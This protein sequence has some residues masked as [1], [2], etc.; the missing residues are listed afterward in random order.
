MK[1]FNI[2]YLFI[3]AL[4]MMV[5]SACE[6]DIDKP[7]EWPEWGNPSKPAVAAAE[8]IPSGSSADI[9]AGDAVQFSAKL[10]DQYNKLKQAEVEVTLGTN[11]VYTETFA[12]DGLEANVVS[13]LKIPFLKN[14]ENNTKLVAKLKIRN[15]T[16][17]GLTEY[18]L[19][20]ELQLSV[21]RPQFAKLYLVDDQGMVVEMGKEQASDYTYMTA[22]NISGLSSKIWI[23]EKVTAQ[24]KP[25]YTEFV[26]GVI[27]NEIAIVGES[28]GLPITIVVPEGGILTNISFNSFS[29]QTS[30]LLSNS[31]NG[32][33]MGVSSIQ[34][35]MEASVDLVKGQD[36]SFLGFGSVADKLNV[37][38]FK[39]ATDTKATFDGESGKYRI[40]YNLTNEF[41]Y[42]EKNGATLPDAMWICG[43]GLGFAQAPY[44]AT[45][46]W[47]WNVPTE[48]I[49][50]KKVAN[51][52]FEATVYANGFMFKFFH[53]KGWGNEED[54]RTYSLLPS[55]ILVDGKNEW[56]D[57][58]G[59]CAPGPDFTPGVYKLTIDRNVKT[60]TMQKAN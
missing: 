19:P 8:F 37:D 22:D 14:I 5:F 10:K 50:C 48:Y 51:D 55:N 7:S 27:N 21:K 25:D 2:K 40:L 57:K 52:I 28:E 31:I 42:I 41:L 43:S 46:Q 26:W 45:S 18:V 39:N 56:G 16:N 33:E 11:V 17:N 23:A 9:K 34:G 49:Y 32:I 36:V 6:D 58:T 53:Q 35:Y 47:N 1:K 54:G 59:D 20:E 24:N 38:F 29:F 60:I 4:S 3:I 15:E 44:A 30:N 12:L 13:D